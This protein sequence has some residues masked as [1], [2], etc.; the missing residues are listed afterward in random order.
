MIPAGYLAKRISA[1]PD[2]LRAQQVADIHSVSGCT[3]KAFAD[4]VDF[5]K[6]NGFWLFDSPEIIKDV[7]REHSINLAGTILFYYDV[8]ENEFDGTT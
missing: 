6:H 3:S 8:Y 7:A 1:K 4:Y 5:W 2:W